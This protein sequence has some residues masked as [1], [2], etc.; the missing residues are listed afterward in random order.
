MNGLA[1]LVVEPN[2]TDVDVNSGSHIKVTREKSE[3][4]IDRIEK[5]RTDKIENRDAKISAVN[6]IILSLKRIERDPSE[7]HVSSE[8]KNIRK[9]ALTGSGDN[10]MGQTEAGQELLI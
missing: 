10:S 3:D 6:P 1:I 5:F 7:R 2:R 4:G 9:I 8:D